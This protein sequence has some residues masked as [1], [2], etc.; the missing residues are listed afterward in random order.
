V[1]RFLSSH[2]DFP[3]TS[4]PDPQKEVWSGVFSHEQI[5]TQHPL[6]LDNGKTD[7]GQEYMDLIMGTL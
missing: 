2:Y 6:G 4:V 5:A 1:V 3:L 7:P